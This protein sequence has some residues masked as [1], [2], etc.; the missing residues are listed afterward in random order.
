MRIETDG[1]GLDVTVEGEGPPVVLL[2]GWPDTHDLWRHQVPALTAAGYQVIA[3]DL[4]GYGASDKPEGADAYNILLLAG[5]VLGVLDHLGIE[6][7]H[8]VGHD[9]G[10]ALAWAVTAFMPD[11]VDHL[12]CLSVGHPSAFGSA[13]FGQRQ[14]SWYMLLFQFEGIAE[15]WLSM[16]DFT[17]MREWCHHPDLEAI[18]PRL[19]EPGH[20]TAGLNWYRANVAPE[21][22]VQPPIELPPISAP[23]MGIW[24]SKDF[25]LTEEQMVGSA[26]FV[27]GSWRYERLEGLDHWVM[28]ED[29]DRV[30]A[31][32][33]DFLPTVSP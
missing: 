10:A 4:R 5:D 26:R 6:R 8:V 28:L 31:L 7:A 22:L 14:L 17:N 15:Q 33:V 25:A 1:V 32:L 29:P 24:G 19:R 20:L 23:T 18:K 27:T 12:A 2:H 3:P 21:V 9:W 13:G 30:S 11:R 16:D